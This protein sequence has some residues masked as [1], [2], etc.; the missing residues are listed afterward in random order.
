MAELTERQ[1]RFVQEYLIDR[2]PTRAAIA[3]GYNPIGITKT[4]N[5]LLSLGDIQD[6]ID[7]A[8]QDNDRARVSAE[9]VISKLIDI[10]SASAF[11][12]F[13]IDPDDPDRRELRLKSLDQMPR[14]IQG[15]TIK[16][17]RFG[18]QEVA[19]RMVPQA[20]ALE[21]LGR[22]LALFTDNTVVDVRLSDRDREA[23]Q[24]KLDYLMQKMESLKPA[25]RA[26]F[27]T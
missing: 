27:E 26:G 9:Y 14:G 3:A 2:V 18:R 20:A 22:H 24:A 11:D 15:V 16:T 13:E 25:D 8:A 7:K 10:T 4:A 21:M 17:N 12:C 6:A 1:Q 5:Q 23:K 19:L